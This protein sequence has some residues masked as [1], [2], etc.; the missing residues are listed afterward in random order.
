MTDRQTRVYILK[1]SLCND[2]CQRFAFPIVLIIIIMSRHQ[3]GYP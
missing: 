3:R 1:S 2:N